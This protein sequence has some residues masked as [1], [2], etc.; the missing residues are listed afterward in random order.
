MSHL[1]HLAPGE[2][3]AR[4]F[5]VVRPLNEGGMGAVYVVE[6]LSTGNQR[7]LKLMHPELVSDARL[8]QRFEQEAR[9][10]ARIKSDHIVQV[11]GAGVDE[12]TRTP[13]LAMELLEGEDLAAFATRR[14]PVPPAEVHEIVSQLCHGLAAAHAVGVVHRDLKPENVFLADARREGVPFTLKLLDLGIAKVVAEAQATMTAAVGTP[15]WMAPEQTVAGAEI[16]PATDVW[17]LGLIVFR[18]LTGLSYW[19][20]ANTASPSAVTLL[21]EV[22]IDPLPPATERA[23]RY[24]RGDRLPFGF[25]DWF[26]RCVVR[27]PRARFAGAAEARA[28]LSQVLGRSSQAFMMTTAVSP[29]IGGSSASTTPGAP[30]VVF[31]QAARWSNPPAVPAPYVPMGP[32]HPPL[33]I[34]EP[35]AASGGAASGA[36]WVVLGV[37]AVM[38]IA[39]ASLFMFTR[40]DAEPESGGGLTVVV[41]APRLDPGLIPPL[42][43]P[44]QLPFPL[45]PSDS[46]PADLPD[47]G[48]GREAGSPPAVDPFGASPTPTFRN[49]PTTTPP[50]QPTPQP[51]PQPIRIPTPAECGCAPSDLMCNMRC[52][53]RQ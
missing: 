5:K 1:V 36:L 50:P 8:R 30:P 40:S 7:A 35:V 13:W 21:R 27:D 12:G 28:A 45:E 10:G 32:A 47:A 46:P 26:A 22:C 34:G 37:V 52:S 39:S 38:V 33:M 2:V 18:L 17:A 11:V 48:G 19:M 43:L 16:T 51:T 20:G 29:P 41:S 3:F 53:S 31:G 44:S 25:D 9:I 14:G 6:Q 23:V 42:V 4:D 24:G 49:P 15:L